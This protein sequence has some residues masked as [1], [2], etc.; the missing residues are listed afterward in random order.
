[1]WGE[2][3][4]LGA[5]D[6]ARGHQNAGFQYTWGVDATSN[7][8]N[9][10]SPRPENTWNSELPPGPVATDTLCVRCSYNLKGLPPT[11]N[12]PECGTPVERSLRGDR[13]IY[14]DADYLRKLTNGSAWIVTAIALDC[15]LYVG[16]LSVLN[17]RSTLSLGPGL[18]VVQQGA[19]VLVAGASI[20]GYWQFSAPDPGQLSTNRGQTPRRLIRIAA[21]IK[22]LS[23]LCTFL[24]VASLGYLPSI[25]QI[26][27]GR[28]AT[29]LGAVALALALLSAVVYLADRAA[30]CIQ[31]FAAM[32]YV[33]WL[34]GRIPSPTLVKRA[35]I[36]TWLLP[37]LFV[38]LCC[39][40]Y[41][42]SLLLYLLLFLDLR[43][44]IQFILKRQPA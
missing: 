22:G 35:T 31:F 12:C 44:E 3:Y 41:V 23:T 5:V 9:T 13:L 40:G 37:V 7:P 24:F 29:A 19:K 11:G 25:N 34:A 30:S 39:I 26:S 1:M 28:G 14:S 17:M 33:R 15:L 38:F 18:T 16:G 20:Y 2:A 32:L 10:G 4:S 21:G 27:G 8:G 42:I 36:Y 6:S 43:R